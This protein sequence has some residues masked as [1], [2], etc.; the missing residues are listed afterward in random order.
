ACD[1][2]TTAHIGQLDAVGSTAGRHARERNGQGRRAAA[3]RNL[4]RYVATG[5]DR[6]ARDR[7]GVGVI[8]REQAALSGVG[9]KIERAER[10]GAGVARA[11]AAQNDARVA[12]TG[13]ARSAEAERGGVAG[14]VDTN[15]CRIAHGGR[16]DRH[17]AADGG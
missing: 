1:R 2:K 15:A 10:D 3:S 13:Y 16:A 7:D 12:R 6:A 11:A 8:L 5:A 14:R 9:G 17:T 4:D